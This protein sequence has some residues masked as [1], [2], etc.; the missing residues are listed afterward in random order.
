MKRKRQGG[1]YVLV[2]PGTGKVMRV[3]RTSDLHRRRL[4]HA[5]DPWLGVFRFDVDRQ[6]DVYAEQRGREQLLHE[7]F[8]PPLDFIEP[9]NPRHRLREFYLAAA[10]KMPPE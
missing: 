3:G 4:E 8:Q 10:L 9:I 2:D 6:T 7:K 5:R 1:T